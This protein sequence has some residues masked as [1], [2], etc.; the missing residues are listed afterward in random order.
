MVIITIEVKIIVIGHKCIIVVGIH[1]IGEIIQVKTT[2]KTTRLHLT[3][4]IGRE[5]SVSGIRGPDSG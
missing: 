1:S 2:S 4:K 5:T 3:I